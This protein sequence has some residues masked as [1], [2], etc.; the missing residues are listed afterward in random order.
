MTLQ[1][2][3][4]SKKSNN[5]VFFVD[6]CSAVFRLKQCGRP[7]NDVHLISAEKTITETTIKSNEVHF[8]IVL[9]FT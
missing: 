2:E 6:V 4:V 9:Q 1:K 7:S 8:L 3:N 5:A